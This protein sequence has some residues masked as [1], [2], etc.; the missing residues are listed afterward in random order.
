MPIYEYVCMECESHFE[1]LVRSQEQAIACPDCT[2]TNVRKQFST[3]TARVS[4]PAPSLTR[5]AGRSHGGGCCGGSCG[6]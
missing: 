4:A 1:E 3:F 2:A 6:C 5:P